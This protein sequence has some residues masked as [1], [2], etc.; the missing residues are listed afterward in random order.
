MSYLTNTATLDL[1]TEEGS[2]Q[3][4]SDG[5]GEST[6]GHRA[7]V[8][9]NRS[10]HAT[11]STSVQSEPV[12]TVHG[13]EKTEPEGF[14]VSAIVE[15]S[16]ST[17]TQQPWHSSW[18]RLGPLSGLFSLLL[19]AA[20]LIAS[21]GI[22]V[23]SDGENVSS[24]KA[25]PSTYLAIFTAIANISIRYA[26]TQGV[27][28]TWWRRAS[29]GSTIARL[30]SDWRAGTMLRGA[31]T[32]GRQTGLLGLA[33]IFAT[34]VMIDGPLLQ[35]ASTVATIPNPATALLNISMA[36]ELPRGYSGAWIS[37][38]ELSGF[39]SRQVQSFNATIP[40]AT[41][42]ASN[43]IVF[44]AWSNKTDIFSQW[45]NTASLS[46]LVRGCPG[47]CR[48][49]IR[50]P[51][52][53]PV[54]CKTRRTFSDVRVNFNT[55]LVPDTAAPPLE[56]VGA[57]MQT[58]VVLSQHEAIDLMTG[59]AT[60]NEDCTGTFQL[61]ACTFHS[62]IGEYDVLIQDGDI[63]MTDLGSPELVAYANNTATD[64]TWSKERLAY[65]STL[66]GV[67]EWMQA[68][69]AAIMFYHVSD[70]DEGSL[71]TVGNQEA[72]QYRIKGVG[73]TKV[74]CSLFRD[75]FDPMVRALNTLAV[76]FG[77]A[78]ALETPEYLEGRLDPGISTENA[79]IGSVLGNVSVYHTDYWFFLGAAVLEV[80]CIIL[81][82][83]TYWGWWQL[84][85]TVSFSP[86]EIAKAFESPLLEEYNSN[87]GG[88]DI[89]T[90]AGQRAIRYGV[91]TESRGEE[92]RLH[93]KDAATIASPTEGMKFDM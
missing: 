67:S 68:G 78:A 3:A 49:K 13:G 87:S 8:I 22:L 88:D 54:A 93:F 24:W 7:L 53:F 4:E 1:I 12:I 81:I 27:I 58:S 82:L 25:P 41:G 28:I 80:I 76:Y 62:G 52:L 85:R 65:P 75:P 86:F 83:P 92:S 61:Q 2:E 70:R 72:L 73:D 30:Q 66:A 34:I 11:S 29:K 40:T 63:V 33:C 84:G 79:V 16:S 45:I 47:E 74:G 51:A 32:A 9:P 44:D 42:N 90:A 18:I 21:L 5:L 56:V 43:Y 14:K 39:R 19:A 48:A 57:L 60:F 37:S 10:L 15:R 17:E 6:T 71:F 69:L 36:P 50:A 23:G 20:S 38:E 35:R 91:S 26:V 59:F 31:L 46:G 55:S 89:A 64:F 77:A